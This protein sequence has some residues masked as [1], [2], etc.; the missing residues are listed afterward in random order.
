MFKASVTVNSLNISMYRILF[1]CPGHEKQ[2]S[3]RYLTV[4]LPYLGTG[5]G[6]CF[7]KLC[8]A[9]VALFQQV[10]VSE[11]SLP[12][13]HLSTNRVF[14]ATKIKKSSLHWMLLLQLIR[15]SYE[16]LEGKCYEVV[17]IML[18]FGDMQYKCVH[19]TL[20]N[21][22]IMDSCLARL[23]TKSRP[24]LPSKLLMWVWMP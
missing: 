23:P 22:L 10:V 20:E 7:W 4:K 5:L 24:L 6:G 8:Q 9:T 2:Q 14:L 3:L 16:W 13:F 17:M 18:W 1:H 19:Y 15:L 21:L 11:F 12:L